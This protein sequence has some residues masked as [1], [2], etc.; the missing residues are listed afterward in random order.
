VNQRRREKKMMARQQY[1]YVTC[2]VDDQD[3]LLSTVVSPL[4]EKERLLL[5]S[6]VSQTRI[7]VAKKTTK[8]FLPSVQTRKER[9]R[10]E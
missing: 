4:G 9:E 3:H 10:N 6:S 1:I 2:C 8:K 7:F 5:P